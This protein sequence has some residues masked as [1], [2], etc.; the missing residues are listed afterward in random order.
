M[1]LFCRFFSVFQISLYLL[2]SLF[3]IADSEQPPLDSTD[4]TEKPYLIRQIVFEG[5]KHLSRKQLSK[6]I[7][8]DA[9][10]PTFQRK[11]LPDSTG[12]WKN[13]VK[14][15]LYSRQSNPK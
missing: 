1:S 14:T 10:S 6:L 4:N 8:I 3:A 13:T 9:D 2:L 5:L 11:W 15:G 7:G 12:Y